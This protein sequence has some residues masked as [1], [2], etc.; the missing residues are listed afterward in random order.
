MAELYKDREK[1]VNNWYAVY[2]RRFHEKAVEKSLVEKGITVYLPKVPKLRQWSDRRKIV[3]EPL[4]HSYVFVYVSNRDYH[5][6]LYT[7]SVLHYICNE[8]KPS[9]IP[10]NQIEVLKKVVEAKME[11][12]LSGDFIDPGIWV[13]I[14]SGP[15]KGTVGEIVCLKSKQR[16]I[17]RIE[18]LNY[19]M[20][21]N[22]DKNNLGT[23]N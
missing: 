7:P 20:L 5:N 11:Y 21:V 1:G 8:G 16:I 22:I 18:Q 17:L 12:E 10:E 4:F 3:E 9:I 14:L 13:K 15:L 19:S 6:V 2:T 23:N